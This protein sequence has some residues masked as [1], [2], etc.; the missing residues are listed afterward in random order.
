MEAVSASAE[1]LSR[2]IATT[3]PAISF[4]SDPWLSAEQ[5]L[6]EPPLRPDSVPDRGSN[7]CSA[8]A[9]ADDEADSGTQQTSSECTD[10]EAVARP[11]DAAASDDK[12][13]GHA[14]VNGCSQPVEP[15][16]SVI[17]CAA[18][19]ATGTCASLRHNSIADE[20]DLAPLA[21]VLQT[22]L[23]SRIDAQY[24]LTSQAVL[25]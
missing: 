16:Q 13:S 24:Q 25:R 19:T 9:M 11:A 4:S 3:Q 8:S 6:A 5:L 12:S 2:C 20:E 14:A 23:T 17:Q 10:T 22:C 1:A 15:R 7:T 18:G 21:D